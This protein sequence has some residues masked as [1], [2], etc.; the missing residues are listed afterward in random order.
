MGKKGGKLA[1]LK[2]NAAF[3]IIII[4]ACI[5]TML[6]GTNAFGVALTQET[7]PSTEDYC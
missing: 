7:V 4:I 3:S 2:A 6:K 1:V 5:I